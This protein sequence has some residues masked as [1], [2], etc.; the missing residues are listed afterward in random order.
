MPLPQKSFNFTLLSRPFL[1]CDYVNNSEIAVL[2]RKPDVSPKTAT[3]CNSGITLVSD[4]NH[5]CCIF[6][7]TCAVFM[8]SVY[9]C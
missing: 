7:V 6:V 3:H 9:A 2:S 4:V 5:D 1:S 8:S